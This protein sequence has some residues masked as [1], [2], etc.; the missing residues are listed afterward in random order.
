MAEW[1]TVRQ[2]VEELKNIIIKQIKEEKQKIAT[3][4]IVSVNSSRER[5]RRVELKE[6]PQKKR[7]LIKRTNRRVLIAQ[8]NL[9]G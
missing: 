4:P 3:V 1:K 8:R 5:L 7:I 6:K 9:R 2:E